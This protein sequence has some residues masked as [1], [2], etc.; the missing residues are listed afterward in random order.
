MSR[1]D[2]VMAARRPAGVLIGF[3][4]MAT[5]K[6]EAL[7]C[8]QFATLL[9][10]APLQNVPSSQHFVGC[11][12]PIDP[13]CWYG[14]RARYVAFGSE[15]AYPVR[16]IMSGLASTGQG[17]LYGTRGAAAHDADRLRDSLTHPNSPSC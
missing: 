4:G 12:R 11:N 9:V 6:I 7:Q 10:R 3:R 5:S 8:T 16:A 17:T 14:K 1:L 2:R 15:S 13:K